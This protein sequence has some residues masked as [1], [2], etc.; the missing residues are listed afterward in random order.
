MKGAYTQHF[1][2]YV[3]W[4]DSETDELLKTDFYGRS[5]KD[6]NVRDL[7]GEQVPCLLDSNYICT[8]VQVSGEM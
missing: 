5:E 4:I 6:Q 3:L 1:S 8:V 7:K 2:R